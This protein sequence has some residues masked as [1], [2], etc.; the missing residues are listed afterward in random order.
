MVDEILK[1]NP[2]L[3]SLGFSKSLKLW[4]AV[5]D[6]VELK[7]P[8]IEPMAQAVIIGDIMKAIKS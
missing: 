2:I 7:Y 4:Q 5:K 6:A 3:A 1:E 8:D